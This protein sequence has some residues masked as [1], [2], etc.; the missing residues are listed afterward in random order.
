M[1][2]VQEWDKDELKRFLETD[3]LY[4]TIGF[5]G[6]NIPE[7]KDLETTIPELSGYCPK[8]NDNRLFH[9]DERNRFVSLSQPHVPATNLIPRPVNPTEGFLTFAF[10]CYKNGCGLK[11]RI[12]VYYTHNGHVDEAGGY[13]SHITLTKCGEYP[14]LSPC[15]DEAIS[16]VFPDDKDLLEKAVRCLKDGLGVGA[17]AYFRQVLESH[18]DLLITEIEKIAQEQEDTDTLEKLAKLRGNGQMSK[19]IDLAKNALPVYL[20][21]KGFNPLGLLYKTLSEGIHNQSDEECLKKANDIYNALTFILSTLASFS[22]ARNKY[23]D[24]LKSL[25]K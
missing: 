16:K 24:S 17:Y 10:H 15:V 18:I 9:V 6:Q 5:E 8:C 12:F 7:F 1:E 14:S 23:K 21:V 13:F 3:P 22:D 20:R 11:K 4:T 25:S 2:K 19:N